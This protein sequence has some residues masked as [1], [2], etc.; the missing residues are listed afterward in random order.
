M[1][2]TVTK[3]INAIFIDSSQM[4]FYSLLRLLLAYG[5]VIYI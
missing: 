1:F 4:P 3:W 2:I 5:I